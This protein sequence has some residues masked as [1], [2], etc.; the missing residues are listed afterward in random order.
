[1]IYDMMYQRSRVND[2]LRGILVD[3]IY[4]ST[5]SGWG[6]HHITPEEGPKLLL[7]LDRSPELPGAILRR[8]LEASWAEEQRISPRRWSPSSP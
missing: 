3:M 8:K 2:E 6:A 5:S 7:F 4:E 1:M